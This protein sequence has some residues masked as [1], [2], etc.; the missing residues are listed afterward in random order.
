[1]DEHRRIVIWWL[2]G[3]STLL[4]VLAA[5]AAY[6]IFTTAGSFVNSHRNGCLPSDFPTYPQ[7]TVQEVDESFPVV[8]SLAQCRMRLSS[9]DVYE[10]VNN[11][12]RAELNAGDWKTTAYVE[13]AGTSDLNFERR[14]HP[15]NRGVVS[16]FQAG[17]T[18]EIQ[19]QLTG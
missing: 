9:R 8:G 18:T 19:V 10:S 1:M 12:Y 17:G 14:S 3:A 4:V 16:V 15:S 5:V 2:A 6:W 11:F 7:F 13:G